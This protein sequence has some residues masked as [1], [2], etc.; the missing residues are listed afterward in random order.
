MRLQRGQQQFAWLLKTWFKLAGV[1]QLITDAWANDPG[2]QHPSGPWASQMCGACKGD[3]YNPRPGFFIGLEDFNQYL[4]DERG[5]V[6][7]QKTR[8]RLKNMTPLVK[9]DGG[10]LT[11]VDFY[12]IFSGATWIDTSK[13]SYVVTYLKA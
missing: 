4:A 7:K 8:D 9:I 1:P 2:I 5:H 6:Q 3:G 11:A 12:E 10:P 13:P